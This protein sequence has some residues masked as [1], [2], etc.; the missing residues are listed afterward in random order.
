MI[1]QILSNIG[2]NDRETKV[3]LELLKI[4]SLP[5]SSL[6][7]LLKIP[8]TSAQ[9]TAESLV[10]KGFAQKSNK[11]RTTYYLPE[12]LS[13]IK[14][15]L[16]I[17]SESYIEKIEAQKEYLSQAESLFQET[18]TDENSRSKV[19]F[20]E[21]VDN[22]VASYTELIR[23]LKAGD[24]IYNYVSPA[25]EE[26]PGFREGMRK[27][28]K[29]RIAEAIE[30]KMICTYCD[31]AIRLKLMDKESLRETR[32]SFKKAPFSFFSEIAIVKDK[33][34]STSYSANGLFSNI[35]YDK[36]IAQMQLAIFDLAWKQ[37]E[38][39]DAELMKTEGAKKLINKFKGVTEY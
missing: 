11:N 14:E 33:V 24:I 10:K 38:R 12:K 26:F 35:I 37:A 17:K 19:V 15:K 36:N 9:F 32:L 4:G 2:L 39:D 13:T 21:G 29:K 1:E 8:R 16:D 7:R 23:D 31:D 22:V 6:A 5:A 20:Y 27:F 3:Y 18:H 28:I 30:I 25:T 34:L